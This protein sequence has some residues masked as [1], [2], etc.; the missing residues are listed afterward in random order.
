MGEVSMQRKYIL[1]KVLAIL[2]IFCFTSYVEADKGLVGWWK[3]DESSGDVLHD[4]SGNKNHGKISG[5]T[6]V[7]GSTGSALLFDGVDDYVNCGNNVSLHADV[8]LTVSVWIKV[9]SAPSPTSRWSIVSKQAWILGVMLSE[10]MPNF[11]AMDVDGEG[12]NLDLAYGPGI[13]TDKWNYIAVVCNVE[14][15]EMYVNGKLEVSWV[16]E[17]SEGS[18]PGCDALP[19]QIGRGSVWGGHNFKGFIGEIKIYD[20]AL[21]SEEIEKNYQSELETKDESLNDK[22]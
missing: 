12:G 19:L 22:K 18:I 10:I 1:L 15:I 8:P 13:P 7:K 21:T 20:R 6:W 16:Y 11:E 3:V 4:S 2:F 14:N 17:W 9:F 5:A